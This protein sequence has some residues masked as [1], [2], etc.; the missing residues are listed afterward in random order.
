MAFWSS[1]KLKQRVWD[2]K[3]ITPFDP[4]RIKHAAYELS[5]G[6]ERYVTSDPAGTKQQLKTNEQVFIPPGQVGLLLTD[7]EIEIPNNAI[8]FISIK[9]SIK[10]RGLV[11]VSGFHVDPGFKGRLKFSVYNAGSQNV[12]LSR[13]Q[14][15]FLIWFSDLDRETKDLY[16]GDHNGQMD[17][18]ALDVMLLQGEIPSPQQLKKE[19]Q[20]LQ[21]SLSNVK[22]TLTFFVAIAGSLIVGLILAALRVIPIPIPTTTQPT[23]AT[24]IG[25]PSE[26]K[27]SQAIMTPGTNKAP[28]SPPE[29]GIKS[30]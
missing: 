19:I 23:V 20:D 29:K 21:N 8:G 28:L 9:A 6:P 3:L 26:V 14:R 30:N 7:E 15:A 24:Q 25:A 12:I 22:S 2:G 11:N 4:N 10:F 13:N 17:I 16:D 1:E 27:P 5:V 18:T